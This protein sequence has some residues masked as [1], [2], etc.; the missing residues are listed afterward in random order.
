MLYK[1][2]MNPQPFNKHTPTFYQHF[3]SFLLRDTLDTFQYHFW[4]IRHRLDSMETTIDEELNI[5]F[6]QTRHAL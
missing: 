2:N 6:G 3:R 1:V 5:P 4:C